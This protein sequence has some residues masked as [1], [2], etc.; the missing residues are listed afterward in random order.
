MPC[1]IYES[2]HIFHDIK[3]FR[4]IVK[5]TFH[6]RLLKAHARCHRS[7]GLLLVMCFCNL[8]HWGILPW[9]EISGDNVHVVM[10][11]LGKIPIWRYFDITLSKTFFVGR[12]KKPLGQTFGRVIS[13][14][15]S[16]NQK[17][18]LY[19]KFNGTD[20]FT[21][22]FIVI[23][24]ALLDLRG[25]SYFDTIG[26]A[27]GTMVTSDNLAALQSIYTNKFAQKRRRPNT[28][29]WLW[30][31]E[32]VT[33]SVWIRSIRWLRWAP[34]WQGCMVWRTTSKEST[35]VWYSCAHVCGKSTGRLR[36]R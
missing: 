9:L 22:C 2:K 32:F 13:M 3:I 10:N 19:L 14:W 27:R 31:V 26:S 20:S 36:F 23:R 29:M 5:S 11:Q 18:V 16:F 4:K 15:Y 12:K 1:P 17:W 24:K 30:F 35:K 34:T 33:N 25:H 21:N 7:A 8:G 28:N 6:P